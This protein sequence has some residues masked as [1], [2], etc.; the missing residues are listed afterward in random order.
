MVRT[1]L[2][3]YY[4]NLQSYLDKESRLQEEARSSRPRT[5]DTLPRSLGRYETRSRSQRQIDSQVKSWLFTRLPPEV[6]L[7]T[8]ESVVGGR[9]LEIKSARHRRILGYYSY[10]CPCH[11]T[12]NH[13]CPIL[14]CRVRGVDDEVQTG[15]ASGNYAPLPLLRTC[16]R[17]YLETIHVLYSRNTFIFGQ[18]EMVSLFRAC[19]PPGHW[20]RITSIQ[21]HDLNYLWTRESRVGSFRRARND[22]GALKSLRKIQLYIENGQ[23]RLGFKPMAKELRGLKELLGGLQWELFVEGSDRDCAVVASTLGKP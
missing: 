9:S 11:D 20:N 15:S 22:T 16:R 7:L 1:Q 14:T 13:T 2:Q 6:R 10:D 21:V 8:W 17:I 3:A 12:N 5:L 23:P 18:F 19:I 4:D